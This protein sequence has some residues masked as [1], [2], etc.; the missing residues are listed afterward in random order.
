MSE[1]SNWWQWL[2]TPLFTMS[3]APVSGARMLGLLVIVFGAWWGAATLEGAI[4]RVASHRPG[5]KGG[6]LAW[7][8]ILR[9]AVWVVA[10][11]VGLD[12]LGIDITHLA[13]L[14]GAIGVGIGFGLQSIFSNF[15]SGIVLLLEKTLKEGDFV[16]LQSGIRGHVRE[17]SLRYTRV[18]TNDE[19]DVI[20]P[21]SEFVNGR[22]VNWTYGSNFR[23]LRVPFGVAYGSDKETV[24][25]AGLRAAAA[26]ATTVT[27]GKRRSDVWLVGMGDSS[28]DFE[29]VVW[30]GAEAT[31]SPARVEANYKWHI[32]EEL[33]KAGLEIPFPQRDLHIR[34][35]DLRVRLDGDHGGFVVAPAPRAGA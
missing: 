2:Q 30:V 19:V 33:V 34:T 7:A 27:D 14:G 29:L 32:D 20:V 11:L 25:A 12:Y 4:R 26:V 22:V 1:L 13:L 15:F 6:I 28:L 9:Y 23:R 5:A 21:N 8:R 10:T 18:T 35:G 24:K 17:I 31:S 16:D 3:G